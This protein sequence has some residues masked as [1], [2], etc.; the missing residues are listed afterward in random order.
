MRVPPAKVSFS[1]EDRAAI[2]SKI[3]DSLVS[4]QL[5]L[6][7]LGAELEEAFAAR[8]DTRFGVA[9]NSGTSALQIALL[10]IGVSDREVLV[11]ANTFFATAAAAVAAGA[12]IRFVDCDPET[13][14]LSP[15]ALAGA[16][17]PETAAVIVVHIGGLISPDIDKLQALCDEHGVALVEDAAHAHG[18]SFDGRSAG[19]LGR[20]AAFSFYPTKVMAGGEG[21][22]LLT[23]DEA[24]A[25]EAR[26][27]RDQG[28]ASFLTN[29]HT[30]L[31]SNWR[32]SEPHAAIALSQLGHLDQFIARRQEIAA[33]YDAALPP[34]GL[35]PL[36]VP[37]SA[38]CNYYKYVAFLPDGVDRAELKRA[39]RETFDV[40][41]SGEVYETGLHQQPV[42]A[43]WAEGPLPRTEWLCARH[44]CLP[45]YPDL[46]DTDVH[47]VVESLG[48]TL[49]RTPDQGLFLAHAHGET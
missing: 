41:L 19:S 11:P 18:S 48:K 45:L 2:L 42:F 47:Y 7:H 22:M 36:S 37:A 24:M 25:T 34:I 8:H 26:I 6:G 29:Q 12:R 14:A 28:K 9:V 27:Y 39:M 23:D 20:A 1:A 49:G 15:D 21:G 30:R 10:S 40:G 5:T 32:M 46:A 3:D 16:I 38:S 4:G 43:P 17:S 44:I 31:G 33:L 13:M 35:R